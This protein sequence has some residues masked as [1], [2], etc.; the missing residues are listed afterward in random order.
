MVEY[1]Y[2]PLSYKSSYRAEGMSF[3]FSKYK[4]T[5]NLSLNPN[6]F[7]FQYFP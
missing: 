3:F 1:D 2:K 6:D 7:H 5:T 4:L